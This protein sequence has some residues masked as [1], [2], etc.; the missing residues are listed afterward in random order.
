LGEL[1]GNRP[2]LIPHRRL[3][4]DPAVQLL[5]MPGQPTQLY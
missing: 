2:L 4:V 5:S 1:S 3:P